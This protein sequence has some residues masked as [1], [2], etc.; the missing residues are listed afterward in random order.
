MP[1]AIKHDCRARRTGG[2]INIW[3]YQVISASEGMQVP[4][5]AIILNMVFDFFREIVKHGRMIP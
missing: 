4:L 2:V 3:I 5:A 1:H